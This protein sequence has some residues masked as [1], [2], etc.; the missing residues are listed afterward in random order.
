M[1]QGIINL[2]LMPQNDLKNA[3]LVSKKDLEAGFKF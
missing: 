1:I 2:T 3:A